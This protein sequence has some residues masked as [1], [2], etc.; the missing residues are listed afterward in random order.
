MST[1]VDN[2]LEHYGVK[3]MRWGKRQSSSD[4]SS[5]SSGKS[6][7]ELRA[8]NKAARAKGREERK[9]AAQKERDDYDNKIESARNRVDDDARKYNEAKQQYKTDKKT[10]GKVA[11]KQ[12]LKKHEDQFIDSWNTATLATTKEAQAQM[13]AGVGLLALSAA[14]SGAAAVSRNSW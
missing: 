14:V 3:G 12:I 6:R 7:S 4:S 9:A 5:S 2:Y 1:E 8:L 11:A 10:I 13:I